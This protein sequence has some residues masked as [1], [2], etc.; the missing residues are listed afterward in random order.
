M[1]AA[2]FDLLLVLALVALFSRSGR[3]FGPSPPHSADAELPY[4]TG[5][6]PLDEEGRGASVLYWRFAVLFVVF[7][8][9]LAF[10]LPWALART[11]LDAA[12][13]GAVTAFTGLAAFM[14]AYLWRKGVLSCR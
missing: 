6:P 9:D 3:L 10:L 4:E 1:T 12:A 13:L 5:L 7:D 2:L 11:G 8:A 14:L